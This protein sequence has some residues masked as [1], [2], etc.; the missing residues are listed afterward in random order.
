MAA[1]GMTC[2]RSSGEGGE[3]KPAS[4]VAP[5][6]ASS[7]KNAVQLLQ[8][9]TRLVSQENIDEVFDLFSEDALLEFPFFKSIG[10][11][12][13]YPEERQFA[14]KLPRL[15]KTKQRISDFMTSKSGRQSNQTALLANTLLPQRS[16]LQD[17]CTTKR[18]W[19]VAKRKTGKLFT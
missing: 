14:S 15:S 11:P 4:P 3:P 13:R 7:P 2:A 16:N 18:M 17:E 9:Y 8:D 5:A 10:I 1:L 6:D 12:A 19:P